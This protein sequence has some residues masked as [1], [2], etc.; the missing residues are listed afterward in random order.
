[1]EW[2]GRSCAGQSTWLHSLDRLQGLYQLLQN[3]SG[4]EEWIAF[5]VYAIVRDAKPNHHNLVMSRRVDSKTHANII[6]RKEKMTKSTTQ[7]TVWVSPHTRC[8]NGNFFS[9]CGHFR[10]AWG[11]LT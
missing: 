11:S 8:R 3:S 6:L 4:H 2:C 10:A 9:V 5:R 7:K 1:R